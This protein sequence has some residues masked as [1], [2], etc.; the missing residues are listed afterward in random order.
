MIWL[1]WLEYQLFILFLK[2]KY[3]LE[4]DMNLTIWLCKGPRQWGHICWQLIVLRV[5]VASETSDMSPERPVINRQRDQ[6]FQRTWLPDDSQPTASRYAVLWPC[7]RENVVIAHGWRKEI[8]E[9]KKLKFRKKLEFLK[10]K[11]IWHE[12]CCIIEIDFKLMNSVYLFSI[13]NDLLK[14]MMK[15]IE[16]WSLLTGL[17]SSLPPILLFLQMLRN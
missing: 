5:Y 14:C 6:R 4:D 1:I 3:E 15:S 2:I 11:W 12:L 7:H 16:K 17:S 9:Q 13:N 10:K 8:E